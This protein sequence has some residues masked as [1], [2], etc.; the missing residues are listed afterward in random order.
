MFEVWQNSAPFSGRPMSSA[1]EVLSTKFVNQQSS[2]LPIVVF[3]A[4]TVSVSQPNSYSQHD[5]LRV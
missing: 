4:A 2:V 3:V 1:V 5:A